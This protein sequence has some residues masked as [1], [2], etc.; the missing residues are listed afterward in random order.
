MWPIGWLR[1]RMADRDE[2]RRCRRPPERFTISAVPAAHEKVERDEHGR[3]K[4]LGYVVKFGPWTVYQSGDTMLYDGMVKRLRPFR[5]DVALLPINGAAPERRVAGNLNAKEA[6]W[7]GKQI[8]AKLVI[9][10][11]Y[12]M[13]EF[14]TAPA[15]EFAEAA[16]AE[17]IAI[18]FCN[19][20]NAGPVR[21]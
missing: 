19:A 3:C 6:A 9:P 13:F 10:M 4:Y 7:L 2:R 1:S 15:E 20:A 17:G 12:D 18:A 14:N 11:H 21:N 16:K 5:I 8:G